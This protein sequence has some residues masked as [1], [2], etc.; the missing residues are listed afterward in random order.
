MDEDDP[1]IE[2]ESNSASAS[3]DTAGGTDANRRIGQEEDNNDEVQ[4]VHVSSPSCGDNRAGAKSKNKRYVS[5]V[6]SHFE[7]DPIDLKYATCMHCGDKVSCFIHCLLID[8]VQ[9][10]Y[11]GAWPILWGKL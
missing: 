5:P 7:K 8:H 11:V 10:G 6:W 2:T 3:T 1:T 9:Y 4:V